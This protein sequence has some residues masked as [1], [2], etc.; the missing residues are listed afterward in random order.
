VNGRIAA[1]SISE[2]KGV[3]KK[4]VPGATLVVAH[5]I[6][7]DAHA[8]DWPRQVSLLPLESIEKVRSQGLDVGP[9][10][11]AENLTTAGLDLRLLSPGNRLTIGPDVIIEVTQL[12]KE[13]HEPC[14]IGRIIGRCIMPDEGV[15]AR[16]ING[17]RIEVND[18]IVFIADQATAGVG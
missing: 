12:G 13:C 2:T 8:G 16:V 14:E 17:G 3:R 5:G 4:N 1:I 18:A 6:E 7:G 11:F 10:D 9:G 15:F